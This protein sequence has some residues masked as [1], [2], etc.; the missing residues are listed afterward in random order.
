[1][2]HDLSALL[3]VDVQSKLVP[4]IPSHERVVW[5]VDRLAR[6]AVVMGVPVIGTEQYPEKLGSTVPKIAKLLSSVAGKRAFSCGACPELFRG[7]VEQ[8]RTTVLVAGLETHVCIMQ[9][10]LDLMA[11]GFD[12]HVAVDAVGARNEV[13]HET[14][15]QRMHAAGATLSTTETAIFEW[16]QTSLAPEFKQISSLIRETFPAS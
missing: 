5:N 2:R 13:D 3:V 11:D 14:A 4:V 12:V 16:C 9:T 8:G 15:L 1:M 6:G 7:L 10:V